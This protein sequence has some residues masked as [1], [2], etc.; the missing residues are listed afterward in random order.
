MIL[1]NRAIIYL[2]KT[3]QFNQKTENVSKFWPNNEN[4]DKKLT[5][6]DK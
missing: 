3:V 6:F 1:I 2:P 4:L 5:F